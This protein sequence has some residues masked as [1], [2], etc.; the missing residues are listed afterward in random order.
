MSA[1]VRRK[2]KQ[3]SDAPLLHRQDAIECSERPRECLDG[4][5]LGSWQRTSL[6]CRIE[7]NQIPYYCRLS[8]LREIASTVL[9]PGGRREVLKL[10][11][12]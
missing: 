10:L 1:F 5:C 11:H 6:V 9:P 8:L 12:F 4:R 7:R 2:F 3:S